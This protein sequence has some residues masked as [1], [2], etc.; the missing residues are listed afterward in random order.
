MESKGGWLIKSY[1][2]KKR[3]DLKKGWGIPSPLPFVTVSPTLFL[4]RDCFF[5]FFFFLYKAR[6]TIATS[7]SKFS[8]LSLLP[9]E[10]T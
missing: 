7:G 6:G 9:L 2:Y 1:K 8:V 5:L 10:A 4:T 3:R